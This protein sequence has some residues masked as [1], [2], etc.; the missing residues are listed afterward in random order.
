[1]DDMG[2]DY[3]MFGDFHFKD[4]LQYG[5]AVPML[6]RLKALAGPRRGCNSA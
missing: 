4:D 3:M 2:Y 5:D 6:Q 1:M